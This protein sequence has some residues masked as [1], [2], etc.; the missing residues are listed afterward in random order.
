MMVC[1]TWH[2]MTFVSGVGLLPHEG[3]VL[4][5]RELVSGYNLIFPSKLPL[6]IRHLQKSVTT[7]PTPI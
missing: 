2:V 5:Y 3:M 4:V 1:V 7:Q 6:M